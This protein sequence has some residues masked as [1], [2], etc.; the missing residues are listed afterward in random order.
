MSE[1]PGSKVLLWPGNGGWSGGWNLEELERW[2][3]RLD[4]ELGV[5]LQAFN[6]SLRRK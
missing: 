5:P 2:V 1:G 6:A 3:M 4:R